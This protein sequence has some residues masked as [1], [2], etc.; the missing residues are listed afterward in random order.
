MD[1]PLTPSQDISLSLNFLTFGTPFLW[2]ATVSR[3]MTY[4]KNLEEHKLSKEFY[5]PNGNIY[6]YMKISQQKTLRVY[7]NAHAFN[8]GLPLAIFYKVHFVY[9]LIL[10]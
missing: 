1:E 3:W 5:K 6:V 8:I 9:H 4:A 7:H 10:L 2:T